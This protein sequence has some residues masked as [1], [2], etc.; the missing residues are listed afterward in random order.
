VD[1]KFCKP[2][3]KYKR[4]EVERHATIDAARAQRWKKKKK[5]VRE[6]NAE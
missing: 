2:R 1:G 3:K 4:V 6:R 5:K